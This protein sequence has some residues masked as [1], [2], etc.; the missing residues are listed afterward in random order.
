M[1][2]VDEPKEQESETVAFAVMLTTGTRHVAVKPVTG[3]TVGARVMFPAKPRM[4]VRETVR[5][6]EAPVLKL[7]EPAEMVKSPT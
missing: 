5:A 6:L 1:L 4:L 3:L 7:T 2:G